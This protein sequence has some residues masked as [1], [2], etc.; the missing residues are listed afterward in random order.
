[1][2]KSFSL[3]EG[4]TRFEVTNRK[5]WQKIY[6]LVSV[7]WKLSQICINLLGYSRLSG[8]SLLI[9]S[10]CVNYNEVIF[11]LLILLL[12]TFVIVMPYTRFCRFPFTI[13]YPFNLYIFAVSS[14]TV[15]LL[16]LVV[17]C[18]RNTTAIKQSFNDN[19]FSR[20]STTRFTSPRQ[21][22]GVSHPTCPSSGLVPQRV[23]HTFASNALC[24]V[25]V[26]A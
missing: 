21:I 3:G 13:K 20:K 2:W 22:I 23:A 1:M 17:D 18:Y 24:V 9:I 6:V 10:T 19:T 4:L 12:F 5:I 7:T 8:S 25:W 14:N 11:V 16:F 15:Y 26:A